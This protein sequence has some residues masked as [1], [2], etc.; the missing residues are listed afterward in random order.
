MYCERRVFVILLLGFSSGLPLLL[1]YA[2]LSAWLKESGIS[3]TAIG[4]FSWASTA[5]A[6][7]FLWSPLVDRM[8]LPF[9][10]RA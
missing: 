9:L 10:T 8:P 3:L 6:I 5:Y 4:L 2:T 7:K 1:V